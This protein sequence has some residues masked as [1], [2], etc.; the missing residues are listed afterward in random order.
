M[1]PPVQIQPYHSCTENPLCRW[2]TY[3]WWNATKHPALD[4]FRSWW[5]DVSRKS[6][7][8]NKSML[9]QTTKLIRIIITLNQRACL[10]SASG[11]KMSFHNLNVINLSLSTFTNTDR[12]SSNNLN[13][14]HHCTRHLP[15]SLSLSLSLSLL[16]N[17]HFSYIADYCNSFGFS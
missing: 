2:M 3:K 11:T 9:T 13:L 10:Q 5:S 12:K 6:F 4:C 15:L 8:T 7:K 14:L 16:N 17:I 1:L